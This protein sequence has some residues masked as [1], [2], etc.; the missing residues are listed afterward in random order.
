MLTTNHYTD[1]VVPNGGVKGLKELRGLVAPREKQYQPTRSL[2]A[3]K[4]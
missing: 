3:P 2:I 1:Q 4:D